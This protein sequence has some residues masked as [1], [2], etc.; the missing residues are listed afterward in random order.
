[1]PWLRRWRRCPS[2]VNA[3]VSGGSQE[4]P[5]L[6]KRGSVFETAGLD[7]SGSEVELCARLRQRVQTRPWSRGGRRRTAR[8][9]C[10]AHER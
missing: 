7:L 6:L 5:E 10:D 8:S 1:V 2:F 3:A 9:R 4:A